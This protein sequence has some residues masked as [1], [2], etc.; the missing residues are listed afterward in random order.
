MEID[1][2]AIVGDMADNN[3]NEVELTGD[4]ID[5][6]GAVQILSIHDADEII[7]NMTLF[8]FALQKT[9]MMT[10]KGGGR[11]TRVAEARFGIRVET[12]KQI[13]VRAS[14][15]ASVTRPSSSLRRSRPPVYICVPRSTIGGANAPRN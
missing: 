11:R 2:E 13:W 1:T 9:I 14:A 8:V 12:W 5:I 3:L 6:I 15:Q 10:T 7:A 4:R